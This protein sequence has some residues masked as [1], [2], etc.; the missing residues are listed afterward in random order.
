MLSAS[1]Q[2]LAENNVI[3]V[4]FAD[5]Q[6]TSTTNNSL[7]AEPRF[8]PDRHQH[9]TP[10]SQKLHAVRAAC[11]LIMVENPTYL[12]RVSRV[13][14]HCDVCLGVVPASSAYIATCVN[15]IRALLSP[16]STDDFSL[17]LQSTLNK[18]AHAI[19]GNL[20]SR[21]TSSSPRELRHPFFTDEN[22]RVMAAAAGFDYCNW[23][24]FKLSVAGG[25]LRNSLQW[26]RAIAFIHEGLRSYIPSDVCWPTFGISELTMPNQRIRLRHIRNVL[27]LIINNWSLS[28]SE[29]TL[30]S[31]GARL[32]L[33]SGFDSTM[34]SSLD[35]VLTFAAAAFSAPWKFTDSKQMPHFP[36][37][38]WY[39]L[40]PDVTPPPE[41]KDIEE[42]ATPIPD[43]TNLDRLP[44]SGALFLISRGAQLDFFQNGRPVTPDTWDSLQHV[45]ARPKGKGGADKQAPEESGAVRTEIGASLSPDPVSKVVT[46]TS[47]GKKDAQIVDASVLSLVPASSTPTLVNTMDLT[48]FRQATLE[49]IT[50]RVRDVDYTGRCCFT[51]VGQPNRIYT[52]VNG[53]ASLPHIVMAHV[54]PVDPAL[55]PLISLTPSFSTVVTGVTLKSIS[56]VSSTLRIS[57]DD[58]SG[59]TSLYFAQLV[60]NSLTASTGT[61]AADILMRIRLM[62]AAMTPFD[63]GGVS[64]GIDNAVAQY[65]N[66]E[67]I[68]TDTNEVW[69]MSE[70]HEN[71]NNLNT[72]MRMCNI[73]ELARIAAG[74]IV[75]NDPDFGPDSWGRTTAVVFVTGEMLTNTQPLLWWTLAHMEYPFASLSHDCTWVDDNGTPATGTR[76]VATGAMYTRCPGPLERVLLV[77]SD[78]NVNQTIN[79]VAEMR[80]GTAD[81]NTY[82]VLTGVDW[83]I[84]ADLDGFIFNSGPI[85]DIRSD[86]EPCVTWW[87]QMYGAED[88][89]ESVDR[90][91]ADVVS[92][93]P[94]PVV[95]ARVVARGY[96]ATPTPSQTDVGY[97]DLPST[98]RESWAIL[99]TT[100][101]G[102]PCNTSPYAQD[103]APNEIPTH[104]I[105]TGTV[106]MRAARAAKMFFYN[107]GVTDKLAYMP[108]QHKIIQYVYTAAKFAA[109]FDRKAQL[110]GCELWDTWRYNGIQQKGAWVQKMIPFYKGVNTAF[111]SGITRPNCAV[112]YNRWGLP[113]LDLA[114]TTIYGADHSDIHASFCRVNSLLHDL[115]FPEKRSY[116]S[117]DFVSVAEMKFKAVSFA[118]VVWDQISGSEYKAM[119]QNKSWRDLIRAVCCAGTFE[120]NNI[121]DLSNIAAAKSGSAPTPVGLTIGSSLDPRATDLRYLA[122]DASPL[123]TSAKFNMLNAQIPPMISVTGNNSILYLHLRGARGITGSK[124]R[125]KFQDI[126]VVRNAF[127]APTGNPLTD[128][129]SFQYD[130]VS[131]WTTED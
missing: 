105:G 76:G 59:N 64:W 124:T 90:V 93:V 96:A 40:P 128:S 17:F 55:A 126:M 84:G 80:T 22:V 37:V 98:H 108:F 68:V 86:L 57:L 115:M 60:G 10:W 117:D 83:N 77:N 114:L 127:S 73:G 79:W 54:R 120:F 28:L 122:F 82:N 74:R 121:A 78:I 101:L 51:N 112:V 65:N 44:P 130:G 26:G 53:F 61:S 23:P 24:D 29:C 7:L 4:S 42:P 13:L 110:N 16:D 48:N 11:Y 107:T 6:A 95:R 89:W 1:E 67:N 9:L 36:E 70:A 104:N 8:D 111:R 75:P 3:P 49:R 43:Y 5:P 18:R 35:E 113:A 2:V 100:P 92:R 109:V 52:A 31:P 33:L 69:W 34:G 88:D 66:P 38:A 85:V 14:Q 21:K 47:D 102:L 99:H 72:P 56:E 119:L 125:G 123:A 131:G 81:Y 91:M 25:N 106:L 15:V 116:P 58:W 45:S 27:Y 129:E 41:V 20:A 118:N 71:V 87:I 63:L 50:V 30:I 97:S 103:Y 62:Q 32:R 12:A 39:Q 19:N 46:R 94:P